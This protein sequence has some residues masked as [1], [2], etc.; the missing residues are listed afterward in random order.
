MSSSNQGTVRWIDLSEEE[1]K[2]VLRI[3]NAESARK[4]RQKKRKEEGDIEKVFKSNEKRIN[5]LEKVLHDLSS[6]IKSSK[7]TTS[8]STKGASS[9]SSS[10]APKASKSSK[11]SRKQS[12]KRPDWFG[13]P[14]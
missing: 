12:E 1:K 13:E 2:D 14:F 10:S 9:S 8:K 7:S 5:D 11:V 3:R 4:S 6:E